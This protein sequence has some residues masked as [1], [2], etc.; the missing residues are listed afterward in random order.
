MKP[1][2]S[3][4]RPARTELWVLGAA[5]LVFCFLA[6]TIVLPAEEDAFIY[7]RYAWNWAHGRGLVFNAG[8]PVEGF[9][10]P[11]WMAVLALVARLGFDLPMTAPALG[12]AC[13]AAA[14]LA[15]WVLA[16][17]VGLSAFGRLAAVGGLALSYPFVIWSRSGLETPFYSLAIVLACAAYVAAEYPL[18]DGLGPRRSLRW[19]AAVA[20]IAV[21]LGRPEGLLLVPLMAADR[22][23]DRRDWA[24]AVRYVLP[25][26][27]AYGGYLLWRV[28]TFH[29]LVPNTSVKLYPLLIDRSVSQSL[30]YVLY[31][32]GPTLALPI[33]ALLD[34]R[35]GRAARRRLGFLVAAVGLLSFFFNF[36]AGGDYRP[37][38][39][40]LIPT[41]PLALVAIWYGFEMLGGG[42]GRASRLLSSAAARIALLV[43]LFC[44]PLLFLWQSPPKIHG[45]RREVFEPWRDP[46]SQRWHW[47]VQIARWMDAHVP[48]GSVVAFGQMG[49]VPYYLARRG[50]E[51]T[52]IDTLGLIDHPVSQ[53]YRFDRKLAA[54]FQDLRA[55]QSFAQAL[56]T[57]RRERAQRV[58]ESILARRPDFIL[59]ETA[60]EDYRMMKAL[61][62]NPRLAAD[63]R[64][65][66][67]LPPAGP[68]Y[69]RIWI[70]NS[71]P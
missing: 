1:E 69:V 6:V 25:A 40:Y 18:G 59:I 47:G 36:A 10:G 53:V 8:D 30:G 3:V 56:E 51:V 42:R 49:R 33:A 14:L 39:R 58:A 23:S 15:T 48:P 67:G 35:L 38:F 12:I 29:S 41:L 16:R 43:L 20:P 9:S 13:G 24:G 54:L 2:R 4:W 64:E 50:H 55:G 11:L 61:L 22:L 62:E 68:K 27:V 71:G 28:L 31:L 34:S 37:G 21:C 44:G 26:A 7:Y 45:W 60:L 70:R 63:Y 65:I 19:I 32:G 17:A 57:G 46:F 66:E 5:L 52:F